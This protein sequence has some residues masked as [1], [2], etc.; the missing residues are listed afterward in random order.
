MSNLH[1]KIG[2]IEWVINCLKNIFKG[3]LQYVPYLGAALINQ[4]RNCRNVPPESAVRDLYATFSMSGT[5]VSSSV[6]W[7]H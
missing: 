6:I 4:D 3:Q 2:K 1:T 7:E 5:F